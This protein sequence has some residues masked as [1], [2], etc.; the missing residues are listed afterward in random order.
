MLEAYLARITSFVRRRPLVSAVA[1]GSAFVLAILGS[2]NLDTRLERADFLPVGAR[3]NTGSLEPSDERKILDAFDVSDRLIVYFASDDSLVLAKIGGSIDSLV[4]RVARIEG[5]G[6]VRASGRSD[7]LAA[8]AL[9]SGGLAQF[10]SSHELGLIAERLSWESISAVASSIEN[11]SH[12]FP[13]SDPLGV[14]GV[15]QSALHRLV[16]NAPVREVGGRLVSRD[17]RIAFVLIDLELTRGDVDGTRDVVR[18]I[19]S[20][21]DRAHDELQNSFPEAGIRVGVVGRPASYLS[22]SDTLSGDIRRTG[23]AAVLAVSL[24]LLVIFRGPVA[25][26]LILASVVFGVCVAIALVSLMWESVS[27]MSLIFV[28]AVVGLGVDFGLH[29]AIN[30]YGGAT[31]QPARERARIAVSHTGRSIV[32]CCMTSSVAFGS[33]ATMSYP[34]T[35]QVAALSA[36][37]LVAV[38]AAALVALPAGLSW[39]VRSGQ[40]PTAFWRWPAK[41]PARGAWIWVFVPLAAVLLYPRI[42]FEPHPWS[43][44]VRGNPKTIE[45]EQLRTQVGAAFTPVLFVTVGSSPDSAL[46]RD[47]QSLDQLRPGLATCGNSGR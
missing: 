16:G 44:A 11:G 15:V 5:V 9:E 37:G 21:A 10:L 42:T 7:R 25:P 19:A 12:R 17:Q 32:F 39:L 28:G 6:S 27:T 14:A 45:M 4:R 30:F 20:L 13:R 41:L 1:F 47:R 33:L 34:V 18:S 43:L 29:V 23:I 36:F 38:A 46:A 22:A 40:G 35:R 24:V 8:A 3:A 31:A 26:A 2:F